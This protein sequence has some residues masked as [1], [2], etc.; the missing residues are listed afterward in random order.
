MIRIDGVWARRHA[1]HGGGRITQVGEQEVR[2]VFRVCG[3]AP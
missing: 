2:L 3:V 1:R